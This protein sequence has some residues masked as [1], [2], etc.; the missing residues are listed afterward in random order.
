MRQV[1]EVRDRIYSFYHG[2]ATCRSYFDD[3]LHESEYVAYYNSMYLLQDTCE[4]LWHHRDKGFSNRSRVAYI[5]FWG[6][7]Q[8]VIIQQDAA[9]ELVWSLTA[10]RPSWDI[11]SSALELRSLRNTCSGHPA[12]K[13]RP[14]G[15]PISRSF[16]ARNFGDY[17]S[18]SYELW[19]QGE[20]TTHPTVPLGAL[21][22]SYEGEAARLLDSALLA[23][24]GRWPC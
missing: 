17:Y 7:M 15:H 24:S 20:G 5:E 18:I 13:D 8:A 3:Q 2:N 23:A 19:Q 9:C 12:L 11:G 16:M 4:S 10:A 22:D 1:S 6:V 14:K 21:L